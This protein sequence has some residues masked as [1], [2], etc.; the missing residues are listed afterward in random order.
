[1]SVLAKR[2]IKGSDTVW[3]SHSLPI[4]VIHQPKLMYITQYEHCENVTSNTLYILKRRLA[5]NRWQVS[6]LGNV[7]Q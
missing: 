4:D 1:M 2:G 5:E 7:K 3:K 6:T